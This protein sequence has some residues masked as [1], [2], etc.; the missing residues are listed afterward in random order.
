MYVFDYSSMSL[1]QPHT[2]EACVT[3]SAATEMNMKPS[4]TMKAMGQTGLTLCTAA[5]SAYSPCSRTH[6]NS[7]AR[8]MATVS[9]C[10]ARV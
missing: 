8:I 4:A 9:T 2:W 7:S 10:R 1:P 6:A 5:G 3:A